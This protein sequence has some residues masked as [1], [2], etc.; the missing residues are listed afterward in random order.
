M[1]KQTIILFSVLFTL[2]LFA[3]KKSI[4]HAD[5]WL[6]AQFY[7]KTI[8]GINSMNNGIHYT[9]LNERGIVEYDY[10]TGKEIGT[11][12]PGEFSDYSFSKDENLILLEQE[13]ESIYR[14]SKKASYRVYDRKNKS[15]TPIFE[16]KKI[17]EPTFSP[18]GDKVAFVFNNNI[19]YQ[20]LKNNEVVQVTYDGVKNKIIN[21]ITD[22]VYEEEFAFVRAFDWNVEGNTIAYIRFDETN[23]KEVNIPIYEK[24]NYPELMTFKYPK[25]GE[26]NAKVSV[27]YYNLQT[28]KTTSLNLTEYHDFYIPKIKFND[29]TG[30]DLFVFISNRHQNKVD[31]LKVDVKKNKKQLLFTETD[32]AWIET[33]HLTFEIEPEGIIWASERDGFNHLYLL[34]YNTGKIKD[35]ITK[36][37]WEV[38]DFYGINKRKV[39][40]Q[41]TEE[42]SINRSI[43]SKSITHNEKQ[44]L[45]SKIGWNDATF[46]NN[47]QYFINTYTNANTPH[48]ITLNKGADGE[49][50]KVLEENN[51]TKQILNQFDL[52]P[53]EFMTITTPNGD[54]LNAWMIKPSNFDKGKEYPVLMYVYGGP[55]SQTVM[56]SWGW[57]NYFWFQQLAQQ[58]YIVVS[59]DNRGTGG[60]G[61][62]F[63]KITYKELGKYEIEDQILAARYLQKLPYVD[64]D[65][66]GMFGWSFG[67]YMTSLAMTKGAGV[68]KTG[69]A[70]APVTNW[71]FYDSVYTERFMQTPQENPNGYDLNSPINHVEKL[72]GN[73]L[74]IH[75]SADDNVHYQNTMLMAEALVQANKEFD[76]HSYTDKNHGIYGGYTRLHLYRKMTNFILE[77]L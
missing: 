46:S 58:G 21:G 62:D 60:K 11:V 9:T 20:D 3:Q 14:H 19:Y 55:G 29:K 30:N 4:S 49:I 18:N 48:Y 47:F 59:V 34:D 1:R 68:F 42:G 61:R 53:E 24:G 7:P 35:Q 51:S 73:Y 71:R 45:S 22:W 77:K 15:F 44:K 13:T 28:Q 27:H 32:K 39:Y 2:N 76:M 63:K 8:S 6:F 75:G 41:S 10:E 69:I 37:N 67:G 38:T 74:L 56:N 64:A 31:V 52:S 40:Y 17:Q 33:D 36:G 26:E 57:N 65:R 23:V 72:K 70:V 25:A 12:L 16:G 5:I 66:M 50:I 43:Y 54:E